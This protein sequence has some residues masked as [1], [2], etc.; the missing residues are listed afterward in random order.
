M[1][2]VG[3]VVVEVVGGTAVVVEVGTL[4]VEVVAAAEVVVE[5][6]TLVVV[7]GGAAVVVEVVAAAE[8]VVVV[9]A[10]V[11]ELVRAAVV[12]VAAAV[13]PAAELYVHQK[14]SAMNH[15]SDNGKWNLS[16]IYTLNDHSGIR[17]TYFHYMNSF[18][19]TTFAI[20]WFKTRIHVE[21]FTIYPS[22][23]NITPQCTVR[24]QIIR[25]PTIHSH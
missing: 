19:I 3:T 22:Y 4:V 24:S 18:P 21:S 6:A 20:F 11:V 14:K 15:G 23:A 10:L 7:V 2:E 5:V 25:T 17:N 16:F 8:V 1:V 12:V 13:G 9:A